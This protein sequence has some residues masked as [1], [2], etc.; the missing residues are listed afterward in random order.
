MIV[1]K[2]MLSSSHNTVDLQIQTV[3]LRAN[4]SQLVHTIFVR[5][6]I[7]HNNFWQMESNLRL[8]RTQT[9][10]LIPQKQTNQ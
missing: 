2:Q 3:L 8:C 4:F 1:N 5:F 7:N 10:P 9:T 6:N